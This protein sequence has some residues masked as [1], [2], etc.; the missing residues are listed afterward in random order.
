MLITNADS[1]WLKNAHIPACLLESG[2]FNPQTKEGL[3]LVDL[4]ISQGVI[5][6]ILLA[7]SPVSNIP[8]VDLKKGL[9][10]PRF[11]DLH[12]HL[13][14]SHIWQRSPNPT[15]TFEQ[16]LTTVK[17]DAEKYWQAEDVLRRMEFSL[18]CS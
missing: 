8:E 9:I 7:P 15:G 13:D 12:T 3:I 17:L 10:F 2:Q 16:A 4:Q 18:Q 5:T 14:K 1:Y 11:I 6:D